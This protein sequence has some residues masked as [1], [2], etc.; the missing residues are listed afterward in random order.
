MIRH[1]WGCMHSTIVQIPQPVLPIHAYRRRSIILQIPYPV[2]GMHT[3]GLRLSPS[4]GSHITGG[5]SLYRDACIDHG[6]RTMYHLLPK[7]EIVP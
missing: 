7:L 6:W 2:R 4:N 1:N 5:W 3:F